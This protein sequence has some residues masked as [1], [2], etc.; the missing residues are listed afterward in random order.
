MTAR[1]ASPNDLDV[2]LAKVAAAAALQD[3]QR[4]DLTEDQ[5]VA[6]GILSD[7]FLTLS[8]RLADLEAAA[9]GRGRM[10]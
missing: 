5:A 1:P 4:G 2:T 7:V 8:L 6:L 10:H 9:R 3:L